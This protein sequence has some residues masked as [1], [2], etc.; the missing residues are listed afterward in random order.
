MKSVHILVLSGLV[1]LVSVRAWVE[2]RAKGLEEG[3]DKRRH[4]VNSA[5][6]MNGAKSGL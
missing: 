1:W 5:L 3:F 4:A 2:G 6:K